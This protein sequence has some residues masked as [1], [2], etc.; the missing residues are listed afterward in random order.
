MRSVTGSRFWRRYVT[1]IQD[2]G[3]RESASYQAATPRAEAN[4]KAVVVLVTSALSLTILNFGATS[5]PFWFV[6]L[7]DGL[8]LSG[9]ADRARGA[10]LLSELSQRNGLVF[11]GIGQVFA[12]TVP[13]LLAIKLV[14]R[15]RV[16][17]YG[18]RVRGIGR[19]APGLRGAAGDL[20]SFRGGG[21]LHSRV[22][23]Q[24]PVLR[25]GGRGGAVA[26]HG[27]VVGGIRAPV[28]GVGVLLPG[29][30]DPRG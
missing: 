21:L 19:H 5:Q 2:Y 16:A 9:W 15:E 3:D 27:S 14:L 23:G 29:L 10:F 7:L 18:V 22:P 20:G 17:A 26:Q 30:H 8:G 24:V 6:T 1:A 25:P 4:R 12:Y 28:R 13:P 11:W